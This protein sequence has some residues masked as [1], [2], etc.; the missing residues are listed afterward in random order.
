MGTVSPTASVRSDVY[1][2]G[3]TAYWMLAGRRAYLFPGVPAEA[4]P[5]MAI[6]AAETPPRLRDVAPHVPSYVARAVE[7]AMSRSAADRF[8]STTELAAALGRRPTRV[9]RWRRT[10]E[11]EGHIACWRGE[12]QSG[13]SVHVTCLE[14]GTKPTQAVITSQHLTS[15]RKITAGCRN[16]PMRLAPQAIRSIIRALN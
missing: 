12:P 5:R 6:V 7:Q 10:D 16:V 15:G 8:A 1:S 14:Q 13:G 4:P 9:R 11:H 3:A 2:L